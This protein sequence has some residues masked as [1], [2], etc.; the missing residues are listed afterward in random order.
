VQS[1]RAPRLNRVL[2]VIGAAV[3]LIDAGWLLLGRFAIDWQRYQILFALAWPL[4]AGAIYYERSRSEPALSAMLACAAFVIES[5]AKRPA[6][7]R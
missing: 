5:A 4:V 3:I 6:A 7:A 1:G 2:F